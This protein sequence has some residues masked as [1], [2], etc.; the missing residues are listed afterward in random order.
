VQF[1]VQHSTPDPLTLGGIYDVNGTED[2]QFLMNKAY[3]T[4][5]GFGGE[6]VA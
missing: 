5:G 3:T 1:A 4:R 6:R 2:V